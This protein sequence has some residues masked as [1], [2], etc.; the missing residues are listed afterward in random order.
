MLTK[1]I[2]QNT[3][4]IVSI[5]EAMEHSRITDYDDEN[6]ILSCLES[7]H[8]LVQQWLNRKLTTTNMVGIVRN[9]SPEIMIPYPPISDITEVKAIYNN[10]EVLIDPVNYRFDD[11][12]GSIKFVKNLSDHYD[13]KIYFS[14]GYTTVPKSIKHAIKMTFATLYEMREDAIIGTQINEVPITARN[15]IKSF[16]A[17]STF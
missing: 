11:I 4:D 17:R 9:F 14:C 2:T 3:L 12:T 7:A 5:D 6:V 8:D 16:K 13:F 1:Q 10:E 15:I